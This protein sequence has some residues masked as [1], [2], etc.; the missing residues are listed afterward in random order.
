MLETEGGGPYPQHSLS[1]WKG[2]QIQKG[3]VRAERLGDRGKP[4]TLLMKVVAEWGRPQGEAV[5]DVEPLGIRA[6]SPSTGRGRGDSRPRK[7]WAHR[8]GRTV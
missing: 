6:W 8:R 4:G 5:T 2:K 7:Q 1:T 3:P